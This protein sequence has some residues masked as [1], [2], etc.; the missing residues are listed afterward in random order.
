MDN[1]IQNQTEIE[2]DLELS[3][4]QRQTESNQT[5]S[6]QNQTESKQN[7][8]ESKQNQTESK[9]NQTESKQ[10]QTDQTELNQTELNQTEIKKHMQCTLPDRQL[11]L[12]TIIKLY[13]YSFIEYQTPIWHKSKEELITEVLNTPLSFNF[14]EAFKKQT[15]VVQQH[16]DQERFASSLEQIPKLID[17]LFLYYIWYYDNTAPFKALPRNTIKFKILSEVLNIPKDQLWEN[18]IK[19]MTCPFIKELYID[20]PP[21]ILR[22]ELTYQQINEKIHTLVKPLCKNILTDLLKLD[23]QKIKEVQL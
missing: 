10:N 23:K 5:E 2:F 1:E 20:V 11:H 15:D 17:M 21:Y 9:Q 18:F 19:C 14:S 12:N 4:E 6:K 8:T 7:Q 3:D 16:K 22:T 13:K